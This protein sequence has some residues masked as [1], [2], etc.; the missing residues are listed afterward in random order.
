MNAFAWARITLV[1]GIITFTL[2]SSAQKFQDPTKEE[3][4]MTSD[5]K[6]PGASAVFLDREQIVDNENFVTT[7]EPALG[8]R[9]P[10][11]CDR[12]VFAN[13]PSTVT[14]HPH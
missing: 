2:Q 10:K 11:L 13:D 4:Q 6:A 12:S 7:G 9:C 3:L 8:Q 5:F 1:L 14:Q